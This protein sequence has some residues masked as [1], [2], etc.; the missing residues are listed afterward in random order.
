MADRPA[1][2]IRIFVVGHFFGSRKGL[3][4]S[5]A[6]QLVGLLAN[7][8]AAMTFASRYVSKIPRLLDTLL[9]MTRYANRYEIVHIHSYGGLALI[10]E[11]ITS[12]WAKMLGKKIVFSL[13]AGSFPQKIRRFPGWYRR[14]FARATALTCPSNYL[15]QKLA[16]FLPGLRVVPNQIN[17]KDYPYLEKPRLNPSL[18]WMRTFEH[19][20]HPEMALQLAALLKSEFQNIRLYMA[21]TDRGLRRSIQQQAIA[22]GLKEQVFFPGFLN[23]SDKLY[24]AQKCDI[25]VCTNRIDN[26]PVSL[27][28]MAALG[29]PIVSTSVGGIPFLFQ[30]R[31]NALLVPSED[32]SAMAA[33]VKELLSDRQLAQKLRRE[34]R[35]LAE[36]HDEQQVLSAWIALFRQI[37]SNRA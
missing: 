16:D 29:L 20:Y 33:A 35:T 27:L 11:D 12:L 4:V 24:Y 3:P 10:L 7:S 37:L 36:S 19:P 2:G 13:H 32:G 22:L 18:L 6:E 17:L 31:V 8:G 21:G 28:E 5:Q 26:A 23:Q 15:Q 25:F 30:H 34:G 14:V 1:S 9:Q